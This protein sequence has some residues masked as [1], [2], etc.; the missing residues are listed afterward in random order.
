MNIYQDE[1][2]KSAVYRKVKNGDPHNKPSNKMLFGMDNKKFSIDLPSSINALVD[3]NIIHGTPLQLIQNHTLFPLFQ[4]FLTREQG[5]KV[6]ESM[7][8]NGGQAVHLTAGVMASIVKRD[9]CIRLCPLCL[10]DDMHDY[11]EPYFHVE[12]Q[13]PGMTLCVKHVCRLI[14][15]CQIC[16]D[17]IIGICPTFCN[18]GHDLSLQVNYVD[19]ENILVH[20]AVELCN[21]FRL[22][23]SGLLK[24][25][26]Y[27]LLYQARLYQMGCCSARGR[28]NQA[29]INQ[30]FMELFPKEILQELCVP[31]PTGVHSWL[32]TMLRSPRKSSHPLLHLLIMIC[33]WGSVDLFYQSF[34]SDN[35][36]V[37][38]RR[39]S[40]CRTRPYR[41][42]AF[43]RVNWHKRDKQIVEEINQAVLE[44]RSC[45]GKPQRITISRIG[46]HIN[47]LV[48]L[49]RHLDKLP[50]CRDVLELNT[51]SNE[52]YQKNKIDWA[53][54]SLMEE[55]LKVNRWKVIRKASI[56]I[57]ASKAI[58]EYIDQK[59]RD[60]FN[61][62][63]AM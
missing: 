30:R 32:S 57:F 47:K 37:Y 38:S 20:V 23:K 6:L 43:S 54:Y 45:K 39:K 21:L 34:K 49:E 25:G 61:E 59:I 4:P 26:K 31:C 44:L 27:Y 3:R 50:L 60:V 16:N 63:I 46:K 29:V 55:G 11:G 14:N 53:I 9:S 36:L 52:H 8:G 24:S 12:H 62:R 35:V 5:S 56:R 41:E 48:M 7:E 13:L 58:E 19:K 1:I 22:C 33:L 10:V 42:Q 28:V 15:H 2:L 51:D 18:N 17:E 40:L